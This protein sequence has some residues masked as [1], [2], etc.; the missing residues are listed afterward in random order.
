MIWQEW[1]WAFGHDVSE[2]LSVSVSRGT[3]CL[4][5]E[6][7]WKFSMLPVRLGWLRSFLTNP[8]DSTTRRTSRSWVESPWSTAFRMRF[9]NAKDMVFLNLGSKQMQTMPSSFH[10]GLQHVRAELQ[11]PA[12]SPSCSETSCLIRS[13]TFVSVQYALCAASGFLPLAEI[14]MFS[15]PGKVFSERGCFIGTGSDL[16]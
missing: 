11:S 4:S 8:S 16:L 6:R 12:P 9:R 2:W 7:L 3:L 15:T 13:A 10:P 14:T 1:F 5:P